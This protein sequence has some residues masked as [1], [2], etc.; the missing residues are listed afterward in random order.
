MQRS[1]RALEEL[2]TLEELLYEDLTAVVKRKRRV[3]C[4]GA[5]GC[6]RVPIY[7]TQLRQP[8]HCTEHKDDLTMV[9]VVHRLCQHPSLC[10]TQASFGYER[11]K[12]L[13]C[14]TH[15]MSDMLNV[16]SRRCEEEY[17]L[18]IP[19]FGFERGMALRCGTHRLQGMWNVSA[20]TCKFEGCKTFATYGYTS[21]K[22]IR[23]S[24]HR[25][26]DMHPT[27]LLNSLASINGAQ[28]AEHNKPPKTVV[29]ALGLP[30]VCRVCGIR[31]FYGNSEVHR[32]FCKQH[33]NPQIHWRVSYC[34]QKDCTRVA[35]SV[36]NTMFYCETHANPFCVRFAP[37]LCDMPTLPEPLDANPL[38]QQVLQALE[39]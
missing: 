29:P 11:G 17:C 31:A 6:D 36:K 18:M 24:T 20:S 26:P 1:K 35:T 15:K 16:V 28:A 9:N 3:I 25:L 2:T 39:Q 8:T 10:F 5:K 34:D 4:Q 30:P 19:S 22:S 27:K 23:C 37:L 14:K 7:G 12:P 13:V 32:A 38:E 33:M 21:K